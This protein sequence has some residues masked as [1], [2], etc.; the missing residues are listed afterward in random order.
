MLPVLVI[1]GP[2][3]ACCDICDIEYAV[4]E[5]VNEKIHKK[6]DSIYKRE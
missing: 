6:Q 1:G 2:L 5:M 4:K 3:L